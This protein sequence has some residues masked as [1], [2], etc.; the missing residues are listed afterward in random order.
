M[1]YRYRDLAELGIPFTRT[2]LNT[3]IKAGRF[4]RPHKELNGTLCWDKAEVNAWLAGR[5]VA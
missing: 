3:M 5:G 4:P 2:H 1:Y